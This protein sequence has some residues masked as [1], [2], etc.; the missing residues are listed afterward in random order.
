MDVNTKNQYCVDASFVIA[1]LLKEKNDHVESMFE[2]FLANKINF[3]SSSLLNFEIGN[4]ILYSKSIDISKKDRLE[5]FSDFLDLE[6][7]L[8]QP[9][10]V[11]IFHLATK[12]S[13]T[14]YDA[15]Y[16]QVASDLKCPLLTLDKQIQKA[17]TKSS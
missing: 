15:S 1:Y 16:L 6:I 4:A 2:L 8:S 9:N 13:L 17:M 5:A 7:V 10:W 11:D 3:T 14:Y 12:T